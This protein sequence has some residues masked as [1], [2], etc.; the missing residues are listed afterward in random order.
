MKKV[1][2]AGLLGTCLLANVA[3][4]TTYDVDWSFGDQQVT[5]T[6]T[7]DGRTGVHDFVSTTL[8]I[9]ATID[10]T[11]TSPH[12]FG[13]APAAVNSG[14]LLQFVFIGL[15]VTPTEI[16]FDFDDRTVFVA[17]N[18]TSTDVT[19]PLGQSGWCM[20]GALFPNRC[21]D[22]TATPAESMFFQFSPIGS[23]ITN[24]SATFSG[25]HVIATAAPVTTPV[26][27]PVPLPAGG[28]LLLAG[29]A[30]ML[31]LRRTGTA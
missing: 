6:I 8:D 19:A 13:G 10:I 28:V 17:Q 5:G 22:P 30:G 9:W 25:T 20:T 15:I 24:L 2:L 3:Q 31:A 4:A 1:F 23:T 26:T 21:I 14:N 18:I 12:L 11:L 7:T 16:I 27:T 29:L